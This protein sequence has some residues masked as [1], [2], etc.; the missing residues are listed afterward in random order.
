MK[1]NKMYCS[2]DFLI[3]NTFSKFCHLVTALL[4]PYLLLLIKCCSP[5]DFTT[6]RHYLANGLHNSNGLIIYAHSLYSIF[7]MMVLSNS[8]LSQVPQE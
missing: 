7:I 2:I 5:V 8:Q 3:S 4:D 1:Q 6:I